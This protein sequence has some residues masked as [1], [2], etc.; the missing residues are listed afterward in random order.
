MTDPIKHM[1]GNWPKAK[2]QPKVKGSHKSDDYRKDVL[3]MKSEGVRV[4]DI[5]RALG[6]PRWMV[7][8]IINEGEVDKNRHKTQRNLEVILHMR[9]MGVSYRKIA[10][11][12]GL[13]RNMV[14]RTVKK[15]QEENGNGKIQS[16]DRKP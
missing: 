14:F 10:A 9:G 4:C 5:V 11:T 3:R 6:V 2:R 7:Y 12:M 13:S 8:T 15:F 1:V 16:R